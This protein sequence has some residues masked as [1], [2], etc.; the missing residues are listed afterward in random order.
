MNDRSEAFVF[1]DSTRSVPQVVQH[2]IISDYAQKEMLDISFYGAE[3]LGLEHKHSQLKSYIASKRS[4]NYLLFSIYQVYNP[5]KGFDLLVIK[6][7]VDSGSSIYFAM[8]SIKIQS[9]KDVN[10]IAIDLQFAH[11]SRLAS[12]QKTSFGS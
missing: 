11:I 1:L 6:S 2:K 8:E 3:L 5:S 9:M 12:Q 4:K 7:C 10:N